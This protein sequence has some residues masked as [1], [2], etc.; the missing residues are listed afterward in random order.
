MPQAQGYRLFLC[1]GKRKALLALQALQ[2]LL[3]SVHLHQGR[4]SVSLRQ[5]PEALGRFTLRG[6]ERRQVGG[7]LTSDIL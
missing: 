5:I 1:R 2:F 4:P 3:Q 7:L 6:V